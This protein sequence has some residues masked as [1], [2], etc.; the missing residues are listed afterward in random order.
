M[1][2]DEVRAWV[3]V[4]ADSP[5]Y[6]RLIEVIASNAELIRVL[7]RV[8]NTPPLNVL[9]AGVQ[10]LMMRG[11]PSPLADYYPNMT[12][13]PAVEGLD[14]SF[15]D[16]VLDHEEELVA[17]GATRYTQTNECRRCIALVAGI[18][19]TPAAVFH[20]IDVGASAGLNLLLDRY[21][22]RLGDVEWGPRSQVVL[23]G[24][25]RGRDVVV[26]KLDVLSRTGLD[27][28]PVDAAN[29]DDAAW[30][31]A[32]VWPEQEERRRRLRAALSLASQ[33]PPSIIRGDVLETLP[34]L[35][36]ELPES[37][38]VVVMNSFILNQ[39]SR[40]ARDAI[41]S[42]IGEARSTRPIYR[43]SYEWLSQNDDAA[44]IHVD[45]GSGLRRVGLAHPHG[46]WVELYAR[47]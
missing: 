39:L 16:F 2:P 29:P 9:L 38:P 44:S 32:L 15:A 6:S 47:P 35:L 43:V 28:H 41:S 46:E 45:D 19:E 36:A 33:D 10:F 37:E 7:N 18:W 34:R 22:C 20:L 11:A 5:L 40:D 17:I 8:E 3:R 26:G 25:N 27:L 23:S 21:R 13:E 1:T 31:E 4:M 30:L 14:A 42:I 24:E 12:E